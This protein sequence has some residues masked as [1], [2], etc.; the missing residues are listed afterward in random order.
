MI[1][2]APTRLQD[3]GDLDT[4]RSHVFDVS[5][6]G[7]VAILKRALLLRLAP[8]HLVIAIGI[9][10]RVDVAE[11]YAVVGKLTKLFQAIAAVNDASV[12]RE[13]GRGIGVMIT[14]AAYAVCFSP[15]R[16]DFRSISRTISSI[17]QT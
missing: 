15:S 2:E 12:T 8:E 7:G 9:K 16:I 3:A 17:V 13:E 14:G 5:L 10:R 11:V 1:I 6:G 4:S